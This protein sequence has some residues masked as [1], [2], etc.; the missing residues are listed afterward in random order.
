MNK[1]PGRYGLNFS[2]ALLLLSAESPA[3]PVDARGL[4]F[5]GV[6]VL[7][8]GLISLIYPRLF[9]NIGIGRKAKIAPPPLYLGMLRFGGVLACALAVVM[10]LKACQP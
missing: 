10:L 5:F 3:A 6:L 2:A 1:N 9:W 8:T 4:F 7:G